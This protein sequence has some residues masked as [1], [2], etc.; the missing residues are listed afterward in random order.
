MQLSG[1]RGACPTCGEWL[2]SPRVRERRQAPQP[3]PAFEAKQI[4]ER[5][6]GFE[7]EAPKPL[8]AA[9]HREKRRRRDARAAWLGR[10][11]LKLA[12][13]SGVL[14]GSLVLV[15]KGTN[16]QLPWQLRSDSPLSRVLDAVGRYFRGGGG[17]L[18]TGPRP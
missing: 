17:D 18:P 7:P 4:I 15:G 13:A 5:P 6:E 11:R 8:S 12:V 3:A 9:N 2:Q 16:W 1:I 14:I 10:N